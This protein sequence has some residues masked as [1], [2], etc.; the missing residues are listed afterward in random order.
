MAM[1]GPTI[2]HLTERQQQLYFL[3]QTVIARYKPQGFARLVDDDVAEATAALASTYETA[4]RGVIYDHAAQ[5]P[6]A[7]GLA[8]DMKAMLAQ[9]QEQGARLYD[10][11]I[12]IA[13]RAIEQ[14]ARTIRTSPAESTAYLELMGTL[15]S[16][17]VA[18]EQ[19]PAQ[20]APAGS[21]IIPG[22]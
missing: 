15:M 14:G 22:A 12:A 9:V 16:G 3:L 10:R 4:A 19:A 18:P 21:L 1:L 11:E 5:S 13:L 17:G 2:R 8:A 20:P 7:Q 6:I